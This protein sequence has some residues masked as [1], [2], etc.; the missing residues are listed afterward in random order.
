MLNSKRRSHF[1][2]A[3]APNL[4][5]R[6]P[7]MLG[8]NAGVNQFASESWCFHQKYHLKLL[9]G[10]SSV[11]EKWSNLLEVPYKN[12]IFI[13][14]GKAKENPCDAEETVSSP[15]AETLWCRSLA[16]HVKGP[17]FLAATIRWR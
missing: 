7:E 6:C 15:S 9:Q 10:Q 17:A 8:V 2:I 5:G 3:K 11:L 1:S 13:L 14:P 12:M 16:L 4:G